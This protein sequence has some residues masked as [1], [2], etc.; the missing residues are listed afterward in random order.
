MSYYSKLIMVFI[1][2]RSSTTYFSHT[3]L[4]GM[5]PTQSDLYKNVYIANMFFTFLTFII[6]I[7]CFTRHFLT[8]VKKYFICFLLT[9]CFKLDQSF[10]VFGKN[11]THH[12][13]VNVTLLSILS[14]YS[15]PDT[16]TYLFG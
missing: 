5:L 10:A 8:D 15:P 6:A 2:S 13:H 16:Q 3:Q 14:L 7:I 1:Y 11:I 12:T 9:S 4:P